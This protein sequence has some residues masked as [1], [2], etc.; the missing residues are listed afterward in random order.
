MA[1]LA[2]SAVTV[3]SRYDALGSGDGR[4]QVVDATLVLTGQGG[5][6]NKITAAILGL[7]SVDAVL[8][9]RPDGDTLLEAR[10]SYDG[11]RIALFVFNSAS[12]ADVTDTIRI[13]A[14]GKPKLQ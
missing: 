1:D 4:R 8:A 13:I 6:S 7:R 5:A 14:V 3:N 9:C 12:A 11:S 2:A 10:P